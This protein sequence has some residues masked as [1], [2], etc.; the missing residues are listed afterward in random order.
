[1]GAIFHWPMVSRFSDRPMNLQ[2]VGLLSSGQAET[3]I[4]VIQDP[5][6][7]RIRFYRVGDR[8]PHGAT[9][10]RISSEGVA[11]RWPDG[12]IVRLRSPAQDPPPAR[13]GLIVTP[14]SPTARFLDRQVMIR[15]GIPL[16]V[17]LARG[18]PVSE[19]ILRAFGLE[20]G[21]MLLEVDGEPIIGYREILRRLEQALER[22]YVT[23]TVLRQGRDRKT[24]T[25]HFNIPG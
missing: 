2:L 5:Q 4:A 8:L 3:A 13:G 21:D 9:L 1:M 16:L 18:Q 20:E 23:V 7:G 15:Q 11:L 17:K 22:A 25:Y 19:G 12:R 14:L 10:D 6:A 24:L